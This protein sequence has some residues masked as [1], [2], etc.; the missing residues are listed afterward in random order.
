MAVAA[1]SRPR[2]RRRTVRRALTGYLFLL[3]ALVLI[4]LF[5]LYPFVQ[6]VALS[7]QD[8]DGIGRNAPWVGTRNYER[9]VAD[10]IFWVSMRNALVFG[11][12]GFFL[13]NA[14]SL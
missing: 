11:L 10:T 12:V 7:F 8:W 9:V 2:P 13:G 3:P 4:G 5:T 6:G 1:V 14:I